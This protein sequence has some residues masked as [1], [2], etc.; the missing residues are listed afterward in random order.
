MWWSLLP[1]LLL[2]ALLA[3]D[4]VHRLRRADEQDARRHA[5]QLADA[6]DDN[7]Q[8]RF[9]AL[10]LLAEGVRTGFRPGEKSALFFVFPSLSLAMSDF[11][12]DMPFA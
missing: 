11:M 1:L 5:Q 10:R 4:N 2:S 7:L 6:I 12:W 3:W 9:A 8:E